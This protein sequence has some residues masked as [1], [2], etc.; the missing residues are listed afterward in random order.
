MHQSTERTMTEPMMIQAITGHLEKCQQLVGRV[1]DAV[2]YLQYVLLMHESHEE[3]VEPTFL[4][5]LITSA[6][7]GNAT[8]GVLR[9]WD[10]PS[11]C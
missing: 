5:S 2:S 1:R 4:T 3:N 11:T 9:K 8:A 6:M 10:T 7:V